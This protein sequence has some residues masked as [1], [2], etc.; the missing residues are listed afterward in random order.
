MIEAY[1]LHLLIFICIY[2]ILAMSLNLITGYA[3][4]LNLGHAAFFGIGAYASVLI[5]MGG[6]P[7]WFGFIAAGA[8]AA[9]FGLL[10]SIPA[11]RL[12]GDFLAIATLAFGE[13]IRSILV[14]WTELTRGPLG[15]PG[16]PKPEFFGIAFDSLWMYFILAF[17]VAA[18]AYAVLKY[19]LNSD[20]GI[21]L[22]AIRE[23]ES[24]A[25]GLGKNV[26]LLKMQAF[27]LGALFAGL[28]GSLFA[29]YITF[30]DPSTFT[31]GETIL[32]LLMVVF[33]GMGSLEGSILGAII[34]I[35]LPEPLRFIGLP[36]AIVG[37]LRQ[38]IYAA[39]L[40]VLVVKKPKGLLGTQW[41]GGIVS[42]SH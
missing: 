34:L 8:I 37:Q 2:A 24:V 42:D 18:I 1:I 17:M 13:I 4:M 35:L 7:F 30:I 31:L 19:L 39:I 29:H 15:I 20:F 9:F 36:S 25:A 21:A 5:V 28:A 22:K 10:L 26:N 12:R 6:F 33:G 27:V 3:G 14:N 40:I 41:F 16:I 38:I 32:I 23:N 11:L